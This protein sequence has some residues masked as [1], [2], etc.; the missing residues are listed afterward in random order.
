[1]VCADCIKLS[2]ANAYLRKSAAKADFGILTLAMFIYSFHSFLHFGV[3][4]GLILKLQGFSLR[5]EMRK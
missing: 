1:M 2:K 3:I 4:D 5:A